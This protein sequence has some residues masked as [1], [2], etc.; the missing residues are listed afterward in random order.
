MTLVEQFLSDVADY[1]ETRLQEDAALRANI[2]ALLENGQ[3]PDILRQINCIKNCTLGIG[4]TPT[5]DITG[6]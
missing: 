6:E 4:F 5:S 1:A 3:R 2:T